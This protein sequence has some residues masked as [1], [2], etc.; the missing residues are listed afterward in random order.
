MFDE[1]F[2]FIVNYIQGYN[3]FKQEE[4]IVVFGFFE[5]VVNGIDCN[6]FFI[7]NEKVC[8]QVLGDVIFWVGDCF[9]KCNQ[10]LCVVDYYDCV[11]NK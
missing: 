9:F 7:C 8:N 5:E 1:A 2:I 3:Y 10:Y 6:C 4:Y 11:V